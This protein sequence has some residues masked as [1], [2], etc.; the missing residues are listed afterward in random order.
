MTISYS[1]TSLKYLSKLEVKI[2]KNIVSV[3]EKLP[4]AGDI[5]KFHG[6]SIEDLYR[7]RVGRFR[8]LYIWR[9]SDIKILDIDTRGDI[10]S[11]SK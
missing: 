5:K 1:R 2:R 8:V 6:T 4:E 7:L 9:A 11:L 3:I 10:Y